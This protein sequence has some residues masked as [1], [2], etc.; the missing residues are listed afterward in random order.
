MLVSPRAGRGSIVLYNI[1]LVFKARVASI[2]PNDPYYTEF[3]FFL[4]PFLMYIVSF[5]SGIHLYD[6]IRKQVSRVK[7]I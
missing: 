3:S 1:F 5:A 7:F 6:C 2:Y 4:V